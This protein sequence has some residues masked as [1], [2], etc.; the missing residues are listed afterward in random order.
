MRLESIEWD[1]VIEEHISEAPAGQEDDAL[2]NLIEFGHGYLFKEPDSPLWK[3]ILLIHP[4]GSL[5]LFAQC[6]I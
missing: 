2:S 4:P 1:Q 5:I 6:E 3:V